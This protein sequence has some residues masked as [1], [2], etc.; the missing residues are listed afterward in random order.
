MVQKLMP[1][2]RHALVWPDAEIFY[3][4]PAFRYAME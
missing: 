2:N 3:S 4:I 1:G